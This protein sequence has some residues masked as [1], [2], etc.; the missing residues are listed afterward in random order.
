M[1]E[2]KLNQKITIRLTGYEKPEVALKIV[3]FEISQCV[4]S[5]SRF[6]KY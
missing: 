1:V 4:I 2:V 5:K 6:L 3:F